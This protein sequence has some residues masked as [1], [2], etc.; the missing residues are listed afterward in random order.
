MGIGGWRFYT[1]NVADAGI[2]TAIVM[3]F[4]MALVPRIADWGADG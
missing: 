2:S 1:Y 4:A 3:L